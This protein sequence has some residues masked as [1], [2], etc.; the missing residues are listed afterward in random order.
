MSANVVGTDQDTPE[1][2]AVRE[3]AQ[4]ARA[5]APGVRAAG[6]PAVDRA[7]RTASSLI[8]EHARELLEVNA[9]DVAA[10]ERGAMAAGLLDRL[11]LDE[12]RLAGIADQLDVLAST[13]EPPSEWPVRTLETG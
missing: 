13:P 3:A 4:R 8:R 10:A 9:A 11:R 6:G 2:R 5:A 1:Y 12:G 7:L